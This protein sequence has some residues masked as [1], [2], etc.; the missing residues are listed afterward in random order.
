MQN[1]KL[2]VRYIIVSSALSVVITLYILWLLTIYVPEKIANILHIPTTTETLS[3]TESHTQ[4][5][6]PDIVERAAPAVVSV[7]ISANVP[8]VERY[9]EN[10]DPFKDFFGGGFGF[11]IPQQR[12]IGTEKREIGG[13]TGFFVSKDGY[14][15]TN[16]H[17]VDT[18]KADY[19]VVTNE[20]KTY[21]VEVIAKDPSLDI[22]VLKVKKADQEFPFLSFGD[23]S[24]LRL[25]SS[26]IAIGNA[27]AEFPNTIS[28][29]VI[30]GLSRHITAGDRGGKTENLDGLIQTDAAI[31]QGNS[32]GP[33]LD[34]QGTVIGVN[35]A[36]AGNSEN[37]GFALPVDMVKNVYAS[38][39]QFGEIIRPY[40]GVR[41]VDI[42]EALKKANNLSVDYGILVIRGEN[43]TD[44]AVIPGS[45]ADK[46]GIE[47]NDIILEMDG[48][49]LNGKENF[50]QI[51]RDHNVGDTVTLKLLHDGKEREIEV[52]LEKMPNG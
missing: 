35:V 31:N 38:V 51:I 4:A 16:R 12:Q 18:E 28:V 41:Y 24:A 23:S 32:G 8:V 19:S 33:L 37:I 22:A 1:D 40:I 21:D 9:F 20:G 17:V 39:E 11:Q 36:V 43:R 45:P 3:A 44:L 42:N 47:E 25:G 52:T 29:G 26:V 27:L 5:A 13:G 14:I 15:I 6:I 2:S 30:S 7:V 48:K 49:K 34:M 10:Y 46:A 50:A